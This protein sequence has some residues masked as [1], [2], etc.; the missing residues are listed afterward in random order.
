MKKRTLKEELERIHTITYGKQ[1]IIENDI[2]NAMV[3]SEPTDTIKPVVDDPEKADYVSSNVEK[4]FND[5]ESIDGM[6]TQQKSGSMEHQKDVELSQIA[7][8]LLGYELPRHG[9]DGLFGPETAE[10]VRKYK[11]DNNVVT[12]ASSL[13]AGGG[14]VKIAKH[15]NADLN[16]T[17]Q[18]KINAISSEY[19]KPFQIT[20]GFRDPAH[21]EKVGGAS[22]SQHLLHNA[23]DIVLSNATKDDTLRFAAIASKNGIGGIG[24][25][26]PGV[27]HIDVRTSRAAWGPDHS[28]GSI[29]GWAAQTL[30][31]HMSNKID[32]GYVPS[33][34]TN[35]DSDDEGSMEIITTGMVDSMIDKLKLRGVTEEELKKLIDEVNTGGSAEFT[36][37]DLMTD[38]GYTKY[39]EIC[40]KFINTRKPNLLEISGDMMAKAAKSAFEKYHKYVPPE[41][42]LAQL[43]T[44]GGIGNADPNSRPIKTK[45]PYNVGNTDDGSNIYMGEVQNG[46]NSYYNL[47]A[48]RY[49]GKGK[50]AKDLVQNFVNHDGNHYASAGDYEK[51]VNQIAAQANRIARTVV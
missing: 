35:G 34:V 50:S 49:L 32:M 42:A 10:A 13:Y 16:V 47:I 39:A 22:K 28:S 37:L 48:R 3:Q 27:L 33:P 46:I 2:L 38:E 1:Y 45:N 30:N 24:I 26:R 25:Y 20:S 11:K 23:V 15:V 14:N 7:L 40:D 36:D 51:L 21:N 44:E 4:F 43:A 9:I 18:S 31:D 29:P 5:L 19:G 17:L 41:L 6:V 12:E 8:V